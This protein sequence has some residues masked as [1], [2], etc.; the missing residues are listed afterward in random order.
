[1]ADLRELA[2]KVGLTDPKTYAQSGNLIFETDLDEAGTVAVLEETLKARFSFDMRVITRS[3]EEIR[4]IA[5]HHPLSHL[6]LD[7]RLLQVAFLDRPLSQPVGDLI[8]AD[9]H[10]PDRFQADGREVYLAYPNGSARSKLGHA[11]LE[12]RLG[13]SVTLRN[14]RTVSRLAEI[15]SSRCG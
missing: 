15:A 7:H 14:W 12:S 2:T 8:E 9:E 4:E 5:A 10:G 1:M 13:V 3:A 11:L 6:G